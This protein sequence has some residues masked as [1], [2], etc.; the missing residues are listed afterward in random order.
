MVVCYYVAL[1]W[2]GDLSRVSPCL[3][4][5]D[6]GKSRP[7]DLELRWNRWVWKMEGMSQISLHPHFQILHLHNWDFGGR[8]GFPTSTC[9]DP[10]SV[11]RHFRHP[12][13]PAEYKTE[14]EKLV[15]T[16]DS[17]ILN[18]FA[19]CSGFVL[20]PVDIFVFFSAYNLFDDLTF[21]AHQPAY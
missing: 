1:Q 7:N 15:H 2:E 19:L 16:R 8:S 17:R 12:W 9:W 6:P 5:Y 18:V 11:G 14:Q 21:S 13:W 4:L 10:N 20:Y 3:S